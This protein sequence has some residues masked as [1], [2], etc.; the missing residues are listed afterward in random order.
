MP[1]PGSRIHRKRRAIATLR[2]AAT[3]TGALGWPNRERTDRGVDGNGKHVEG[4]VP[5]DI[6]ERDPCCLPDIVIRPKLA[7]VSNPTCSGRSATIGET[8]DA[9]HGRY[10]KTPMNPMSAGRMNNQAAS[11]S[12]ASPPRKP[13]LAHGAGGRN[14]EIPGTVPIVLTSTA[15]A[16]I[17]G[18]H[19]RILHSVF[20]KVVRDVVRCQYRQSAACPGEPR[21]RIAAT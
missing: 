7:V 17:R 12:R 4:N 13:R 15:W 9:T 18:M 6:Q 20:I 2:E 10:T 14:D 3:A 8:D 11:V 21:C 1:M 19:M 5:E 16:Q